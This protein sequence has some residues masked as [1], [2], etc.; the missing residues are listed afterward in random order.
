M[1]YVYIITNK[2]RTVLYIG[3][4]NNIIRRLNEHR[5]GSLEWF[6]SQYN[7]SILLYYEEFQYIN[8]AISREKQLKKRSRKK[9]FD[10]IKIVNKDL[11]EIV[12]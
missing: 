11:D 12:F 4:T 6:T 5:E 3:V 1:Y 9:K 8:D 7:V 10:L 2:H